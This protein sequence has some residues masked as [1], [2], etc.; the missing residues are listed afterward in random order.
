MAKPPGG[1]SHRVTTKPSV[2]DH[3]SPT[4]TSDLQR[5][6]TFFARSRSKFQSV[7]CHTQDSTEE[8]SATR[9]QLTLQVDA[10][11]TANCS[12]QQRAL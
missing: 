5:R 4:T 12:S 11:V 9:Q 10:S 2:R 3:L 7:L 1:M 6:P 8:A